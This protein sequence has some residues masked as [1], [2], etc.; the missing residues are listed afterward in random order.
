M[1]RIARRILRVPPASAL[2]GGSTLW[3]KPVGGSA[4]KGAAPFPVA[5]PLSVYFD[6]DDIKAGAARVGELGGEGGDAMP[7]PGVGWFAICKDVEGNEFGLWQTDPE[8]A[9][10]SE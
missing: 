6:V 1:L 10:P 9:L 8:A 4:A 2:R 5:C 7:V 3:L